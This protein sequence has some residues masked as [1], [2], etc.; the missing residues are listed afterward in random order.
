[1]DFEVEVINRSQE[2][3]VVVDFWAPWCG[4]CQ[5]I[6]PALEELEK[7]QTRWK[8]V[9]VNV[10][11]HPD[12][13][14]RFGIR[15]IPDVRLFTKGAE[16]DRFTGALPRHQIEK[17]L[18]KHIPD[19]RIGTLDLLTAQARKNHDLL[20]LRDFVNNNENF[21]P[22][23]LA[24]AKLILWDSPSESKA[25]LASITHADKEYNT[26]QYLKDMVELLTFETEETLPVA[27]KLK[28]A[29]EAF[30]LQRH[31]AG[32]DL[33]IQAV[34]MNKDFANELPR[35]ASI[36]FFQ[37]MGADHELTKGYRRRFDMA[38]Y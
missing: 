9:K 35:R 17:W 11:E 13:S 14:Q 5:V 38:L 34:M 16:V 23:F 19:E 7:A 33:L 22:G 1:M 29:R 26:A 18:E 24:L 2:I 25:L 12:I 8:L 36:A 3:P 6:G 37:V 20:P 28:E 10:D 27:Q 21:K 15:G 4:P 32:I 30:Q 31:E